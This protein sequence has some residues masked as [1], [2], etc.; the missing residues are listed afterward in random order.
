MNGLH[1]NP[2]GG[3]RYLCTGG[4]GCCAVR[5]EEDESD[6]NDKLQAYYDELKE[7]IK[8]MQEWRPSLEGE[9]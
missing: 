1:E 8:T 6:F 9:E 4:C 2:D 5:T 7:Q 3:K